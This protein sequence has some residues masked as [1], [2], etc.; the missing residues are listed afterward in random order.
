M[1]DILTSV[2]WY[3]IAVLICTSLK[4]SDVEHLF[5]CLLVFCMSSLEKCLFRF[6]AH[7]LIGL[8]VFLLLS[9]MSCLYIL[10]IKPLLVASF[11]NIF[12]YSE[13]CFF[14]LFMVF[15]AVQKLISLIRSHL[16]IFAFIS[17]ALGHQGKK[18]L[19]YVSECFAYVLFYEFYVIVSY[20]CLSSILSLFL[21]MVWESVLTSSIYMWLSSFPNTTCWRDCLFSTV[22]S[23]FLFWRLI[24]RRC[25]CLFLGS[26]FCSIDPYVCFCANT[27][28]FLF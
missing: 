4:I 22:Y 27:T 21:C 1:M 18:T 23:C 7:F 2:R 9:C 14:I 28:L 5:M 15:F 17:I 16:F 26:L 11:A 19:I 6:S 8:F 20:I 24:D 13:G 12:S 10:E 25:V 3:L